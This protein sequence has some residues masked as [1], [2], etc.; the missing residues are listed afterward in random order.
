M[1][2]VS[3]QGG[4]QW[5]LWM[6]LT[7]QLSSLI[8]RGQFNRQLSNQVGSSPRL[9]NFSNIIARLSLSNAFDKS[10]VIP[11]EVSGRHQIL[12]SLV[13]LMSAPFAECN[14]RRYAY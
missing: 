12:S 11:S 10:I 2:Q 3:N 9:R 5:H 4:S 13:M 7:K 14:F 8:D 6:D 1:D